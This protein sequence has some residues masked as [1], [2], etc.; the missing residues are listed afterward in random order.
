MKKLL[1]LPPNVVGVF[2]KVTE[3]SRDEY[4][5]TSDPAGVK[6]GSGGGTAWLLASA[7][8]DEAPEAD[9]SEWLAREKRILL[10]A[11]GQSRRLPAYA[12][13][14]KVLTPIPVFR[15]T[16]GQRI[17][18]T[19]LSLQLP[20]YRD[21]MRKAPAG[22]RTLVASGD[23]LL[24]ATEPLQPIPADADVVCYGLWADPAQASHHGVFV[25]DRTTPTKLDFML[26]K[27]S[28]QEQSQLLP[29]HLMLMDIGV[30]LLSDK[31][32]SRLMQKTAPAADASSR[33]TPA[34]HQLPLPEAYDLYSEFGCALGEHPSRPDAL[35]S[36]LKVAILPLP[37][38]E[39]Y[40]YG[41]GEDMITSSVQIQNLVKDQ[42]YILQKGVKP[43]T[44]VFTQNTLLLSR[45]TLKT[46][47]VWIENAYV[48]QGWHYADHHILTGIPRNDWH[49]E[50]RSGECVDVVPVGQGS[51]YALRP[52]GFFDAFRGDVTSDHTLYLGRPVTK[53]LAERGIRPEELGRTDDLQAARLFPV[54]ADLQ[55][56]EKLLHWFLAD[57][58]D[59]A[60]T[61]TWRSLP[62]LSADELSI[63]ADLPRLFAQRREMQSQTLPLVAH[64][65]QRSV[66]YQVN[67]KDMAEKYNALHL[68]LPEPLSDSAPL[69]TRIHDAM[70]RSEALRTTDAEQSARFDAEA[71]ALLREGLTKNVL[72]HKS[73][74]RCTT[75]P[76]QIVWGRSSVR[77]D[78]AGGWTDTP[79][80]SLISGGNVVNL[81]INLNGQPPLQ[82]YVKPCK[83]P[84]I[85]CRSIDLGAMERIET[86][87]ELR[88]YNKVG[89]PFSIP[90]AALTLA[91]FLP[92]FG[93]ESYASLRQQL[94]AFGC[95]IEITLLAAIPAGSGLGTSSI[96]AAT[97]L[98]ALSDFCGLGWDRNEVCNRTLVLEQLLTTGGGWQDQY[99]GVLPGV[100][101]LQTSAGFDQNAVARWLPDTLFTSP[102]T[103]ACHLLYYTGV[104]RTAK[105]ILT[106]IVRGMFLNN[107]RH[108]S[109]LGSMKQHALSLFD[110]L[111]R[112]DLQRY[113]EMVRATWEQNKALDAG[114]NPDVVEALCRR[115]D[116]LCYGYKLPGA[117]GGGFMYMVAKDPEAALRIRKMLT[118]SPLTASS[119]FVEM[120]VS[121]KGL[122]VSRS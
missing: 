19:L 75:Y 1:S 91:G 59:K 116:D 35:L 26:Q 71:F 37:G 48:G 58:P 114:T 15:W 77:I 38:G 36:D 112:N 22:L 31:A 82:V 76:D 69:M 21:I 78:V 10:H 66:F 20:L 119:R 108:L 9:F 53:W 43:Q 14:G 4:Y 74:P 6:L 7:H 84:V 56:L 62:R 27:P 64:N 24:R 105:H 60:Q 8:A 101:L 86:Y 46:N 110:T 70:F 33:P 42:R 54:S 115:V 90:K 25:M 81:A 65:W 79:P 109:I 87:D 67:L 80:Y 103:K 102:E 122:Q 49:V 97:V 94:E 41:T 44:S 83:E 12:P 117:G 88:Q 96:L 92:G 104:T 16:R 30:W 18:Q 52:Y 118:E 100:K 111:Q 98:A 17:D 95:G 106:E 50:L 107:T 51:D 120:D 13:S 99:G 61:E 11:G 85:I 72:R 32:V 2:H 55:Q 34:G 3:L 5:C 57:D 47:N 89:S 113:G 23:V 29:T 93:V 121:E 73:S 68:S 28:T 45:P 39:F 40:H 63:K